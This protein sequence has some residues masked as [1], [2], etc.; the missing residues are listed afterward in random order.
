MSQCLDV[1]C[2]FLARAYREGV[3]EQIQNLKLQKLLYY[4]QCL[5]LALYE[6][7]LFDDEFQAW[8]YGPVCPPVYRFYRDFEERQAMPIELEPIELDDDVWAVLDE[9]WQYFSPYRAWDLS[10]LTHQ[11]FPW[12]KARAGLSSE[13]S[14]TAAIAL[15]DMQRL[16]EEWLDRI[17]RL[18]PSYEVD[19]RD[20]VKLALDGLSDAPTINGEQEV[21]DWL[22]SILD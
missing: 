19:M 20:S 7:P 14:S 11:E 13:A 18:H 21:Y 9:V 10:G 3:A 8:R 2:F 15:E 16:G 1:A 4:S 5:Y 6:T 17:E 12:K 22:Q